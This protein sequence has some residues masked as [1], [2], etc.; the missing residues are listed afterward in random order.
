MSPV[1]PA[2]PLPVAVDG[3]LIAPW[4]ASRSSAYCAAMNAG[5]EIRMRSIS[6]L[7]GG[8]DAMVPA[9]QQDCGGH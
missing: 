5:F 7:R 6:C 4:H 1:W 3:V 9:A 8:D 2:H